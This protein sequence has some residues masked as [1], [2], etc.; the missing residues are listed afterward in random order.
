MQELERGAK[1]PG[2]K[3][4]K[5]SLSSQISFNIPQF[6]LIPP[7][8]HFLYWSSLSLETGDQGSRNGLFL[9]SQPRQVLVFDFNHE[10]EQ[11]EIRHPTASNVNYNLYELD[12]FMGPYPLKLYGSWKFLS[13]FIGKECIARILSGNDSSGWLLDSMMGSRHSKI[14][15][16]SSEYLKAHIGDM[17]DE[18]MQRQQASEGNP[19]I[20]FTEIDLKLPKGCLLTPESITHFGV[21]KSSTLRDLVGQELGEAGFLG[22]FQLSYLFL[23]FGFNYDGFD[24]WKSLLTLVCASPEYLITENPEFFCKFTG[25]SHKHESIF[26]YSLLSR[27]LVSSNDRFRFQCFPA[28][29]A[30]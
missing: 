23:L 18:S 20:N 1:V 11:L 27:M 3:V 19:S 15:E 12:R 6:R 26:T 9:F 22:E 2:D 28:R 5:V 30:G 29:F 16:F 7:G 4:S 17:A 24:Q 10:T 8:F 25:K 21:D 13:N 14:P